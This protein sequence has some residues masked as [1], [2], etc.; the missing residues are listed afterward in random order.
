[1]R[2]AV[3]A[4]ALAATVSLALPAAAQIIGQAGQDA[5]ENARS[6]TV[7]QWRNPDDGATGTFVP[8]P[9]FQDASGQICREFQQ[10][11]TIGSQQQQAWGMACRQGDGSWKLQRAA[12]ADSP[13]PAPRFVPAPAPVVVYAP[14]PPVIY[15]YPPVYY[16]PGYYYRRPYYSSSIYIGIGG[17]R[18][19]HHHGRW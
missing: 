1:M 11:V 19:H 16:P 10:T 7:V 15:D 17:G 4:L 6:G 13:P 12:T 9:A 8:K 18:R 2:L 5:L 14:P 3:P